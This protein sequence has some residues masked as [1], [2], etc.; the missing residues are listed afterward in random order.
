MSFGKKIEDFKNV[1]IFEDKYVKIN[2]ENY[3]IKKTNKGKYKT[4]NI[5]NSDIT[6]IELVFQIKK[7]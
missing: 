5:S 6:Y 7:F 2:G 4:F 1:Q 3:E